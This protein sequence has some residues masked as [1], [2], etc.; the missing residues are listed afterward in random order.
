MAWFRNFYRCAR[1]GYEW[2]DEWSAMCEDDCPHCGARHMSPNNS[3]DA[4]EEDSD[5]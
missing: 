2:T 3:E 4:G 1:C 5:G